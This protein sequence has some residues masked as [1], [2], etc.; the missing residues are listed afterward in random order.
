[1]FVE[2]DDR[3]GQAKRVEAVRMGGRLA[4]AIPTLG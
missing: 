2:T 3:S 1:V 4:Q